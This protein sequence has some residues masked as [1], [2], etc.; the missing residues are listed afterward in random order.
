[1]IDERLFYF[2]HGAA[3]MYFLKAGLQRYCD[4]EATRLKRLCGYILL[5]WAFLELKD[6]LFYAAPVVRNELFINTVVLF[7]MTA[8]PLGCCFVMEVL[9]TGWCT[10]RRVVLLWLPFLIAFVSY[11]IFGASVIFD[12]LFVYAALFTLTMLLYLFFS[13]K[14]YNKQLEENF[15]NTDRINVGWLWGV[16]LMLVVCLVTWTL[17][18]YFISWIVD[19]CYQIMLVLMWVVALHYADKQKGVAI[20]V[21]VSH[22]APADVDTLLGARLEKV[23]NEEQ[24]WKNPHLSLVDLAMQV[25]TNRTYLSNYLNGTLE[26]TFY[27]YVNDFR[28]NAALAMLHDAEKVSTMADIAESSGFNSISTFRRVFA[29]VKG[30]SFAE[31]KHR[32][33][34]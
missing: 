28:I 25:G 17:S 27:D 33:G 32:M 12:A 9:R 18:C 16:A 14:K 10:A 6:L 2:I 26:T 15:S 24:A 31:Y 21:D 20:C 22:K 11:I 4:K 19:A 13:I 8:V 23:M 3:T 7:D 29:R 30:C 5:Y 34:L 1:M